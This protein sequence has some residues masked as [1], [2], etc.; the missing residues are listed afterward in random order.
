MLGLRKLIS[1]DFKYFSKTMKYKSLAYLAIALSLFSSCRYITNDYY[2]KKYFTPEE[3]VDLEKMVEFVKVR[4]CDEK[5]DLIDCAGAN[6]KVIEEVGT[7][8]AKYTIDFN[9]QKAFYETLNSGILKNIWCATKIETPIG[10][11]NKY[12][13][14]TPRHDGKYM[15]LLS[16][17]A[18][19][20]MSWQHFYDQTESAFHPSP[21]VTLYLGAPEYNMAGVH[22]KTKEIIIAINYLAWLDEYN[23]REPWDENAT[24]ICSCCDGE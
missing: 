18:E 11:G 8:P 1:L 20:N 6:L 2:L 12:R 22:E 14:L 9:E 23:R 15:Q 10:S 7:I 21:V 3:I 16:D 24:D 4:V 17:L 13:M 19:K 5:T